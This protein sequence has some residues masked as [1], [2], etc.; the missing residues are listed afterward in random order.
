MWPYE[1]L[2]EEYRY[3][4]MKTWKRC[5]YKDLAMMYVIVWKPVSGVQIY[6]NLEVEYECIKTWKWS[7]TV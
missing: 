5:M 1:D 6:E 3:E 4:S 7:M 2:E